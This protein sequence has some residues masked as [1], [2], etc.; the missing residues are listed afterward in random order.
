MTLDAG[1]FGLTVASGAK[2]GLL[3]CHLLNPALKMC[4]SLVGSTGTGR[5]GS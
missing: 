1:L 3:P 5:N 2:Q 4:D